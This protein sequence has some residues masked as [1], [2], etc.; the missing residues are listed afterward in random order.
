MKNLFE[1]YSSIEIV[2]SPDA[3]KCKIKCHKTIEEFGRIRFEKVEKEF[4]SSKIQKVAEELLNMC[5]EKGEL[6]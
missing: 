1:T 6:N 5:G 2:S 3:K 4:D